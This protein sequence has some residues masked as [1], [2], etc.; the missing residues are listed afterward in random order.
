MDGSHG[1]EIGE[2]AADLMTAPSLKKL[3]AMENYLEVRLAHAC[4]IQV[5][6]DI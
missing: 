6:S 4:H 1:M 2:I 3:Q 5:R